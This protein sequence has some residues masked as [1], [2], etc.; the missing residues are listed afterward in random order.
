VRTP[1]PPELLDLIERLQACGGGGLEIDADDLAAWPAGMADALLAQGAIEPAAPANSVTCPGCEQACAMPVHVLQRE[2]A[3]PM[4][5]T[6][7]DKRDDIGRVPISMERLH[8]SQITLRTVANALARGLGHSS[9]TT[10]ADG[11]RLGWIDGRAGRAAVLLHS[12]GGVMRVG[13]AGHSL[14][15]L[16]LLQ[17]NGA[18]MALDSSALKRRADAPAVGVAGAAEAPE[19]RARRLRERKAAL[20]AMGKRAFLQ[21]IANEEGVSPSRVKQI[22][23]AK[24]EKAS[25]FEGLMNP[26]TNHRPGTK[27]KYR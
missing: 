19:A 6:V 24:L 8:R 4:A 5:F 10:L 15:I 20:L 7:C 23:A 21:V 12:S 26:A 25:P 13:V 27:G 14:E 17:W 3:P 16:G 9:P 1:P 2:D 22:L 18:H 11:V